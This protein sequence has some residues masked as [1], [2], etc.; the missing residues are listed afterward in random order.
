MDKIL[1][2]IKVVFVDFEECLCVS[3]KHTDWQNA[4]ASSNNNPYMDSDNC[5]ELPPMDTFLSMC[6]GKGITRV[7]MADVNV[8]FGIGNYKSN[9]VESKY[10]IYA[11]NHL[12]HISD[13]E[14]RLNFIMSY[15]AH[16]MLTGNKRITPDKCLIVTADMNAVKSYVANGFSVMTPQE[17][18]ARMNKEQ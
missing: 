5:C 11:I 15:C 3:L 13:V 2:K 12:V 9:F 7:C 1:K 14:N 4:Y 8:G 17:L 16:Q 10:G 6:R 18:V